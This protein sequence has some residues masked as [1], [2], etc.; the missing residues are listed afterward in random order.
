MKIDPQ[1]QVRVRDVFDFLQYINHY[2]FFVFT[3]L[4]SETE[5]E[6]S[7]VFKITTNATSRRALTQKRT[8]AYYSILF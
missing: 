5:E 2:R 8:A 3:L 1:K 6:E 4:K 7:A